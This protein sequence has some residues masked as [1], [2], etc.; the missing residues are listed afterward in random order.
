MLMAL[1]F[2]P[3]HDVIS[4][5]DEL[6]KSKF[7]VDHDDELCGLLDYYESTWIGVLKRNG[8]DRSEPLFA[9]QIWNCY[10]SVINDELRSNN[11]MEGWHHSFNDLVRVSHAN[12]AKFINVLRSQQT[13]VEMKLVQLNTGLSLPK[14][15]LL[16]R[17][18]NDRIK[19]IVVSYDSNNKL[20]FLKNI[21]GVLKI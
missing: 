9:I 14:R 11:G 21:A 19:K 6:T 18:Y 5:Y 15:R 13:L 20:Q 3:V 8:V 16:Y 4:A 2:V 17:N 12:V 7:Y 1:A 10:L